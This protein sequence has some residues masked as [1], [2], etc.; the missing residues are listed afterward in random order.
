MTTTENAIVEDGTG[1]QVLDE[2]NELI[3]AEVTKFSSATAPA[4]PQ[5]YQNWINTGA[6]PPAWMVRNAENTAFIKIAEF[7]NNPTN[8]IRFFHEG[9][10]AVGSALANV[11]TATQTIDRAGSAG[12][13]AIGSDLATGVAT[14]LRMFAHNATPADFDGFR[15]QMS[16]TD[17]TAAS[18]DVSVVF[19]NMQ[20][21]TLTTLMTMAAAVLTIAGTLN[22]TTLQQGGTDLDDIIDDA[23]DSLDLAR[24]LST[25]PTLLQTDAGKAIRWTGST[26]QDVTCGRLTLGTVIV[27]HNDGT[28]D[29]TCVSAAASN[30]VTFQNGVTIAAG[31]TATLIMLETGGTQATN[32]WRILGENT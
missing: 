5:P 28:A 30:D 32:V 14:I 4:A 7:L 20:G 15:I 9:A 18:E 13:M 31:K 3:L 8:Q 6:S 17:S 16:V 26:A 22:A 10:V 27:I 25:A 21:G 1:Q 11:F 19:Q 23:I 2:L 29:L 12:E 24:T